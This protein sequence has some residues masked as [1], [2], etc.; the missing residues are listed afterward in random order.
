MDRLRKMLVGFRKLSFALILLA[1]TTTLVI[2]GIISGQDYALILSTSMPAFFA[3]NL[4]E[5]I[6]RKR[7]NGNHKPTPN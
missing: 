1:V 3:A 5:H 7:F 2:A 6:L 4:G